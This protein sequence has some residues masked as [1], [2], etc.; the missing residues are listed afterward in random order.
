MGIPFVNFHCSDNNCLP[1]RCLGIAHTRFCYILF[2]TQQP[3][4]VFISAETCPIINRCVAVG[5]G[6]DN[7]AFR[8]HATLCNDGYQMKKWASVIKEANVLGGL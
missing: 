2:L 6:S 1:S 3:L 8:Q 5:L 7:L 4:A